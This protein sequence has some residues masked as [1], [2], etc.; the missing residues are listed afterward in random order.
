MAKV[1]IL[2][3]R[4]EQAPHG[5]WFVSY[6]GWGRKLGSLDDALDYLLSLIENG[7]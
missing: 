2:D 6:C 3:C 1:S 7:I 4:I 5:N